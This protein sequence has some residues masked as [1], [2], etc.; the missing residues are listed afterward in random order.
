MISRVI[1]RDPDVLGGMPVF[2]GTRVLARTLLDCLESGYS[3]DDFLED[4]PT[5]RREQAVQLLE[6]AG[7]RLELAI[8]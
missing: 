6:E 3:I 7:E 2:A 5:V 1:V 8:H 4:F